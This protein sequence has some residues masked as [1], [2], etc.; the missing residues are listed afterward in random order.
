MPKDR[1]ELNS[2]QFTLEEILAEYGVGPGITPAPGE[3]GEPLPGADVPE[4]DMTPPLREETGKAPAE[5]RPDREDAPQIPQEERTAR[6]NVRR[7]EEPAREKAQEAPETE[8]PARRGLRRREEPVREKAQEPPEEEKKSPGNPGREKVLSFPGGGEEGQTLFSRKVSALRR[9]ADEYAEHMFEQEGI[10]SDPEVRRAEKYIPGVDR[11]EPAESGEAPRRRRTDPPAPDR[12]A[13]ELYH[14]Y[15]RG[16]KFLRLRTLLV[17]LLS[18]PMLYV[19]LCGYVGA[20][21]PGALAD[22]YEL[23]IYVLAGMMGA[24]MLLGIDQLGRGLLGIFRLRIGL[25]TLAA[26]GCLA[27]LADALT[28]LTLSPREGQL[29]YCA[30]SALGLALQMW[31]SGLKRRGTRMACRVAASARE[32]YLVT[33]DEGKWNAR[34]AYAKR[35]GECAGFGSQIQA[36]DVAQRIFRLAAPI[37]LIACGLFS[38]MASLGQDRPT[39]LIW[40]LSATLTAAGTFSST[41]CFGV[42]WHAVSRRLSKCAAALAGWDGIVGT[43]QAAGIL[44][45]DVDL[46]PPGAVT[47]NGIKVF[48]NFSVERVLGYTATMIRATG[49]GL[50]KVFHD[51][52]RTQGAIYRQVTGFQNHE[53]G[54]SGDIRGDRVLVGS[55]AF[56]G[57]MR[58]SLPQ[59][60]NVKNAVFCAINGELAGIFA[61]NYALHTA[62]RPALTALIANRVRPVLATRDFNLTPAMLRQRF[63]LPVDRMEYPA[64]ERRM[65]LSDPDGPHSSV[66]TAVLCREGLFSFSE[67]VVGGQRLRLAVRLSAAFTAV[68]AAVGTLLAFYLTFSQAYASISPANLLIFLVMWLVPTALCSG[69]VNRY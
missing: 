47:P 7:R 67:A 11:E 26:L 4:P 60:L 57:L 48:G 3:K 6:R 29:P 27:T 5:E 18:L 55:A 30:V 45:T 8:R 61:L 63:K 13:E 56:M 12:P 62:V 50:D 65:E 14:R 38:A 34:D 28:M 35:S 1:E 44:L 20:P 54:A 53:G 43:T 17:L 31:G 2:G 66:L 36:D 10:E 9:R 49:S 32:P 33:L 42:P 40:C 46:F 25:D 59:G 23:Q 15:G 24:A 58:V 19:T 22:S 68:G 21:L 51:L 37:L 69:W 52:L 39:Y 41:L 16:L 64:V